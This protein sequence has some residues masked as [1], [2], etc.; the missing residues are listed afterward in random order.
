MLDECKGERLEEVLASFSTAVLKKMVVDDLSSTGE[1]P[2]VALSMALENKGY[3]DD[4]THLGALVLAHQ[5]AIQRSR[6]RKEDTAAKFR[7]FTDLLGVKERGITRKREEARQRASTSET[8][9][10]SEDA[11][12]EMRRTVRNNWS[13]NERWMDTLLHGDAASRTDGTLG[14]DFDRV[15]RRVE[16]DRL[17]ELEAE[18]A[19]LLEQLDSRVRMHKDRLNKWQAYRQDM[20]GDSSISSPSKPKNKTSSKGID[21]GFGAHEDLRLGSA[22][23]IKSVT[24]RRPKMSGQYKG[25]LADLKAELA[26]VDAQKTN[27][28]GFL[29]ERHRP[30]RRSSGTGQA[31]AEEISELSDLEEDDQDDYTIT[32]SPPKT[33]SK[34]LESPKRLPVRPRLPPDQ[35]PA[36]LSRVMSKSEILSTAYSDHEDESEGDVQAAHDTPSKVRSNSNMIAHRSEASTP[37]EELALEPPLSPTQEAADQILESMNNASP[38]PSKRNKPRHTLSL[39]DR[40]RLS[41]APRGSSV[42]LLDEDPEPE[43]TMT[44]TSIRDSIAPA[45]A[46]SKTP[47]GEET[48]DLASR[49][50]KSMAGFEKAR[51][52]AQLERRRSQR[53]SKVPPR[54]EGSYFPKLDE[55]E[56]QTVLAEEL[57][58]EEDMEAVFRSRPK[59]KASPQPSPTRELEFEY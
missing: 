4:K 50:R 3:K 19:G 24:D 6:D 27:P 40:T 12:R 48:V 57:I 55:D 26:E 39:A 25:M 59:I 15:W 16:Q 29:S 13:G 54:R 21:L 11:R 28:L 23:S 44:G 51:Q 42:F 1:H 56:E 7:D 36:E 58:V 20:F 49:T 35:S 10:V 43:V 8:T 47:D 22:A 34:N 52:K 37:E 46:A 9:T 33:F 2:A 30:K 31:S 38:S 5:V 17:G 53:R 45:D 14:M 32:A 41:M 18:D